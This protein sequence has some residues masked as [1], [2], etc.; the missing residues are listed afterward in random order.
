MCAN[1]KLQWGKIRI[2]EA[3][4]SNA[5]KKRENILG[6][7]AVVCFWILTLVL[8]FS[9]KNQQALDHY[10]LSLTGLRIVQASFLLPIL[11]MWLAMLFAAISFY[12]YAR[13]IKGSKDSTGFRYISYAL[14]VI[15]VSSIV[16]SLLSGL[17]GLLSESAA[18]PTSIRSTFVVLSNYISVIAA[19][20]IYG[21]LY[22][23]SRSLLQSINYHFDLS[24]HYLKVVLPILLLAALYLILI[25]KNPARQVSQ[26][27]IASPTFALPDA[28]IFLTVAVPY[29]I[30]WFMGILALTGIYLYQEKTKGVVY[31][32]L[33]KQLVTGITV[34]IV[35]TITLQLITQFSLFWAR[36]GLSA[37]LGIIF[38]IYIALI[39]AYVLVAKGAQKLNKI[40]TLELRRG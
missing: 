19:L 14:G 30:S 1:L 15:L 34:L 5:S 36:S 17:R 7:G 23:A 22:K 21:C 39:I 35:L 28:L 2:M 38:L 27:P 13:Q 18:D 10:R 29:I 20:L 25:F 24:K 8:S 11:F 3:T 4:L 32:L 12:R 40:E 26:D 31:K 16:A 37:I 6:Y 33:L 9:V